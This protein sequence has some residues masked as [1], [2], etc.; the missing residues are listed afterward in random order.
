MK[1]YDSPINEV[2]H[3]GI[4]CQVTILVMNY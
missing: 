2:F 4:Y 3:G 1:G